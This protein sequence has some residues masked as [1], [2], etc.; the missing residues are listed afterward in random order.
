MAKREAS[1]GEMRGPGSA[2]ACVESG[3]CRRGQRRA[4][5]QK[6]GV[7]PGGLQ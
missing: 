6:I 4:Y 7:L 2:T 5:D 3:Q 1:K